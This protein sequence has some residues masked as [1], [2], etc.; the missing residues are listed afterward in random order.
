MFF[1][2][3]LRI[4]LFFGDKDIGS[5]GSNKVLNDLS[6]PSTFRNV[7]LSSLNS[8]CFFLHKSNYLMG[9]YITHDITLLSECSVE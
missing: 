5:S 2:I 4:S 1:F 8:G 6:E 3:T 9:P 7:D